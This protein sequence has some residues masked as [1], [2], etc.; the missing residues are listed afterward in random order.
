MLLSER[1][2]RASG[3]NTQEIVQSSTSN[4]LVEKEDDK[5]PTEEDNDDKQ[6]LVL[7]D[8]DKDREEEDINKALVLE[9]KDKDEEDSQVNLLTADENDTSSTRLLTDEHVADSHTKCLDEIATLINGIG[10][11]P[12][13]SSSST[14]VSMN[15]KAKD[16]IKEQKDTMGDEI[17]KL[18]SKI[19]SQR[20]VGVS[21]DTAPPQSNID[22]P[23]VNDVNDSKVDPPPSEEDF[24]DVKTS[25]PRRSSSDCSVA[26]SVVSPEQDR[27]TSSASTP[28]I[29]S[30]MINEMSSNSLFD[31]SPSIYNQELS[32][33]R[34]RKFD[35][36]DSES[37]LEIVYE[38]YSDWSSD[39]SRGTSSSSS[40][41]RSR[42]TSASE[43][44]D[45]PPRGYHRY[46]PSPSRSRHRSRS[47]SASKSRSSSSRYVGSRSNMS[48]SSKSSTPKKFKSSSYK[49]ST[50]KTRS[51]SSKK[52]SS[53][54]KRCTSKPG[55]SSSPPVEN[56]KASEAKD[57]NQEDTLKAE[58]EQDTLPQTN[59]GRATNSASSDERPSTNTK[60]DNVVEIAKREEQLSSAIDKHLKSIQDIMTKQ[61]QVK[62]EEQ[63]TAPD[64]SCALSATSDDN[65][66]TSRP[67]LGSQSTRERKGISISV[68]SRR[69]SRIGSSSSSNQ[70]Q[71]LT[72]FIPTLTKKQIDGVLEELLETRETVT[73]NQVADGANKASKNK[74]RKKYQGEYNEEG[75]RHGY[76]IYTS[77]NGNQY[78]GEWQ[79][80]QR[81]GLG[82]V[83]IGQ[84]DVFE[85]QFKGNLK[86][87]VGVYHYDD[88]E[89]DLSRYVDDTRV[90]DTVRYSDDRQHAFLLSSEQGS[91]R[92]SLEEA[93]LIAKEMGTIVA[94]KAS[95]TS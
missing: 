91:R 23:Q 73:T 35:F 12:S 94:S 68:I 16:I 10:I 11:L 33:G 20:V 46:S 24:E 1:E 55:S 52:G 47:R 7:E 50:P 22:P 77:K 13:S 58:K 28:Y 32:K 37:T 43:H 74:K 36:E 62:N 72:F 86:N 39:E 9:D 3:T 26:S 71:T 93:V 14:C 30:K 38:Y 82:V 70:T 21:P 56:I 75:Q 53:R 92:I 4:T 81:E 61:P 51:T 59:Q 83:K 89:C 87:G 34:Q 66:N 17:L 54:G 63:E 84:G 80:D 8:T 5:A 69:S 6:A 85:G 15:T 67:S 76:G 42:Y 65:T 64:L 31:S 95:S 88:G 57:E 48:S 19:L 41:Q 60:E 45:M 90:G 27:S 18:V 44:V 40:Y 29:V 78:R 25:P 79:H 49:R 2:E